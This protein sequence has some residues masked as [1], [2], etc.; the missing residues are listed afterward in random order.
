MKLMELKSE[1]NNMLSVKPEFSRKFVSI[2]EHMW[3]ESSRA[4]DVDGLSPMGA[5]ETEDIHRMLKLE[6]LDSVPLSEYAAV[7]NHRSMIRYLFAFSS[8]GK[9]PDMNVIGK[10]NALLCGREEE[11]NELIR[12]DNVF[13]RNFNL[14]P[15]APKRI[16]SELIQLMKGYDAMH[17]SMNPIMRGCFLHNELLRIYPFKENNEATARA[18]LNLELMKGGFMPVIFCMSADKYSYGVKMYIHEKNPKVFY[19]TIF[20]AEKETYMNYLEVINGEE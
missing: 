13:V 2:I 9:L 6:F 17:E 20:A 7:N 8:E 4:L 18:L 14:N 5:P 11:S 10:I 19:E 16:A 1:L 15:V 12:T 3:I